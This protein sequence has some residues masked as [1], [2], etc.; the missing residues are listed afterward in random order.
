LV[1]LWRSSGRAS[2]IVARYA[3][4]DL[5]MVLSLPGR[6]ETTWYA[7]LRCHRLV[8]LGLTRAHRSE[9]T[10]QAWYQ[11]AMLG[12]GAMTVSPRFIT[13]GIASGKPLVSLAAGLARPRD[14]TPTNCT[15]GAM[16]G[17]PCTSAAQCASGWCRKGA[18]ASMSI[19]AAVVCAHRC[20]GGWV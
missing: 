13:T 10:A 20:G 7:L 18:C 17:C 8:A 4:T 19:P 6:S 3:G 1:P 2:Q 15:S 9:G 12:R 5:G 16:Y 11:R 14:T